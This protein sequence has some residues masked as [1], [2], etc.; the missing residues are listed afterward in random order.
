M[1]YL[2]L[3]SHGEDEFYYQALDYYKLLKGFV[4]PSIAEEAT[5]YI[6]EPRTLELNKAR[7]MTIL[8]FRPITFDEA[9]SIHDDNK[10]ILFS[11]G[12]LHPSIAITGRIFDRFVAFGHRSAYKIANRLKIMDIDKPVN[13][14][15]P[16]VDVNGI[17]QYSGM[18]LGKVSGDDDTALRPVMRLMA[19]G[20]IVVVP[21]KS[22]F[23][24]I[25]VDTWNGAI[26]SGDPD[27]VAIGEKT[28]GIASDIVTRAKE[29]VTISTDSE[30]YIREFEAVLAGDSHDYN[31]PWIDVNYNSG[32]EW[33]IIK[34]KIKNGELIQI[35]ARYHHRY[36]LMKPLTLSQ[37]LSN[38]ASMR[39]KAVYV[40]D[41]IIEELES[42]TIGEINRYL[43]ILGNRSK[44]IFF[45]IE[46]PKE[47]EPVSSSLTFLP[48]TEA[49]KRV[50]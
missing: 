29:F 42:K 31:E 26:Y 24:D 19:A 7:G 46:P 34:E 33:L 36:Q 3:A 47:W 41:V 9:K 18:P 32:H 50:L 43:A 38:F 14:I 21:N 40:F 15:M 6:P 27:F 45:C 48:I 30:R 1:N 28:K 12:V 8:A 16:W 49:T 17:K 25:V 2:I 44:E 4:E 39:F 10:L 20:A 11:T 23:T 5:D 37:L 13:R 35:P 22:P